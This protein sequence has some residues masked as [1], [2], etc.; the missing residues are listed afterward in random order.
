MALIPDAHPHTNAEKSVNPGEKRR[1]RKG[2][3]TS[4]KELRGDSKT[5][6]GSRED[7]KKKVPMNQKG[8]IYLLGG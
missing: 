8:G 3:G 1:E 7:A 4:E 2:P 5:L 6:G